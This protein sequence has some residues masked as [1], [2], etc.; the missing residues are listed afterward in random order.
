[1]ISRDFE[2]EELLG[3]VEMRIVGSSMVLELAYRGG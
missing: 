1:M 2:L 3:L